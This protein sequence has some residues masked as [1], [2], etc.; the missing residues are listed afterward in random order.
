MKALHYSIDQLLGLRRSLSVIVCAV[1]NINKHPD[2][3]QYSLNLPLIHH[4]AIAKQENFVVSIFTLPEQAFRSPQT[5]SCLTTT[6]LK[7]PRYTRTEDTTRRG[8][9]SSA[10]SQSMRSQGSWCLRQN[11]NFESRRTFDSQVQPHS[12]PTSVA[13]HQAENF[14]R[15]YRAVVSPTHVRVTAGGRIVPNTRA[16]A[17]PLFEPNGDKKS[18]ESPEKINDTEQIDHN[19]AASSTVGDPQGSIIPVGTQGLPAFHPVFPGSFLPPYGYLPQGVANMPLQHFGHLGNTQLPHQTINVNESSS[20]SLQPVRVSHPGQFDPTR[21]YLMVNNQMCFPTSA[22][23]QPPPNGFPSGLVGNSQFGPPMLGGPPGHH[24][25]H[26]MHGPVPF[27]MPPGNFPVHMMHPNGQFFSMM[28]H[29]GHAQQTSMAPILPLQFASTEQ[30][31]QQHRD[32][33]MMLEGHIS[34]HSLQS[35]PYWANQRQVLMGEIAKM[36]NSLQSERNPSSNAQAEQVKSPT[37]MDTGGSLDAPANTREVRSPVIASSN[38]STIVHSQEPPVTQPIPVT[39][40]KRSADSPTVKQA[41]TAK[42]GPGSRL[43]ATAAMAPP[44]QPRGCRLDLSAAEWEEFAKVTDPRPGGRTSP[45]ATPENTAQRLSRLMGNCQTRWE[46]SAAGSSMISMPRSQTMPV[47]Q[48][49]THPASLPTLRRSG[50]HPNSAAQMAPTAYGP[51]MNSGSMGPRPYSRVLTH[52]HDPERFLAQKEYFGNSANSLANHSSTRH[53]PRFDAGRQTP[54]PTSP[55]R[56]NINNQN[57]FTTDEYL[58]KCQS[59]FLPVSSESGGTKYASPWPS[60][61]R[62]SVSHNALDAH[63]RV[64]APMPPFNSTTQS[65][66]NESATSAHG[67]SV[68]TQRLGTLANVFAETP[69]KYLDSDK[70]PGALQ[71]HQR[72]VPSN[73][74]SSSIEQIKEPGSL[75]CNDLGAIFASEDQDGPTQSENPSIVRQHTSEDFAVV[76]SSDEPHESVPKQ[77]TKSASVDELTHKDLGD[78]F[79]SNG[80]T[81]SASSYDVEQP[82][83]LTSNRPYTSQDSGTIYASN[84]PLASASRRTANPASTASLTHEDLGD[85]F[86]SDKPQASTPHQ[87]KQAPDARQHTSAHLGDVFA[88]VSPIKRKQGTVTPTYMNGDDVDDNNSIESWTRRPEHRTS[89][90][91]QSGI[92]KENSVFTPKTQDGS[93][94]SKTSFTERLRFTSSAAQKNQILKNLLNLQPANHSAVAAP[95]HVSSA[96]AQGIVPLQSRGSAAASLAPARV[97][98]AAISKTPTVT[99]PRGVASP[100]TPEN[101]SRPRLSLSFHR[102]PEHLGNEDYL[103]CLKEIARH[104]SLKRTQVENK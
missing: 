102:S 91:T 37:S 68:D 47:P 27:P 12:A 39:H 93:P 100:T 46:D 40:T 49:Q 48:F 61:M 17:P 103:D 2:I 30:T 58:T 97:S 57:M 59:M 94:K 81:A 92:E 104:T 22:F 62:N 15:F 101:R 23:P 53:V 31:L 55:A 44:F 52:S 98:M 69:R 63:S 77:V 82:P 96:N 24:M 10:S 89:T 79:A 80:P 16:M 9:S 6:L 7:Q 78:I 71:G 73:F 1:N 25:S 76:F 11:S 32:H 60:P 45:P 65:L 19:R 4:G 99:S 50:T 51:I 66:V 90:S 8:E 35:V 3:G 88:S 26:P 13:L 20:S 43:P 84:E 83:T 64:N 72:D 70:Q 33:L 29:Q 67:I 74:H 75:N 34:R 41:T 42:L 38:A 95:A 85:I 36:T 21:P 5:Y 54:M 14:R 87:N 18:F 56:G 28:P 86:A